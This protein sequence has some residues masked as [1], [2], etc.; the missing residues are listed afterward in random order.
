MLKVVVVLAVVAV[1]AGLGTNWLRDR[2]KDLAHHAID[3][4]L[5]GTVEGPAWSPVSHGHAVRADRVR[6]ADGHVTTVRCHLTLGTYS[7]RV[8]HGFTFSPQPG[9]IRRGCPGRSLRA[10]LEHATRIDAE[11]SGRVIRLTFSDRDGATVATLRG[12][13]G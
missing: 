12:R 8:D 13:S 7:V 11:P 9:A 6:F 2:G 1:L 5:P 3:L 10:S 4:S